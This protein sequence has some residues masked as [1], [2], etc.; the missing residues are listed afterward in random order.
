MPPMIDNLRR[1]HPAFR[2]ALSLAAAGWLGLA[3]AFSPAAPASERIEWWTS[4]EDLTQRLAPQSPLHFE[5]TAIATS[6]S[7]QINPAVTHQTIVGLGSSFEHSTCYNLS[8]LPPDQREHVLESLVHPTNGIGL[9]LVRLCIGTPDFTASPWYSY[10]DLPPGQTDPELKQFSIARDRDYVLPMIK[11]AQRINP[12]L[13]FFASPWSPPA[14]MKTTGRLGGGAIDRRHFKALAEYFVR[15]LEA[16]REEGIPIH[17]ITLQNEP[18]Y[19]PDTYPTCLWSAE[20]QRDFIRD[21][22][23][24][25][26]AARHL[27]TRIWCYDH[28]FDNLKFPSTILQDPAAARFVDGTAFHH[29]VGQ[30]DAM[31]KLLAAFPDKHVYFTEGS[32]FQTKGAAQLVSYLRNGARCYNA[33][34]TFIDQDR[35]PNP[36]PHPCSLTGVVLD[37]QRLRP[38]YRFDYYMHGQFTKFIRPGAIRLESSQP[39]NAPANVV[40]RTPDG[41]VVLVAVNPD[42]QPRRLN[43]SWQRRFFSTS[44][45]PK[46]LATFRWKP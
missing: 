29:Y 5:T 12:D 44:L 18:G 41:S 22:L 35:K 34:V 17:A 16:Y 37:R 19:A 40:F 1:L 9:S 27:D 6:S 46:S 43:V 25:L 32:V 30:P 7:I 45:S 38:E 23:G 42:A 13:R 31:T 21:H 28:N 33:W 20:E 3:G 10:D 24:P 4:S 14:W 26:L 8:L 15:F 39:A 36:G 11:A 2:R